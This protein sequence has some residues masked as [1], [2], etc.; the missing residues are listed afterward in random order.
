[1][2]QPTEHV[3]EF[4][5]FRL[6]ALRRVLVR[7]GRTVPL[8]GKVFDT[9]LVLVERRGRVL[10][11][12]E[13]MAALWPDTT[14]EENNLTQHVSML[15]KALGE[16]AGAHRYVVTVPGRG[17]TFVEPVR[18]VAADELEP[19]FEERPRERFL[20]E[21][22]AGLS[23]RDASS[24]A[25]AFESQEP[26]VN[27]KAAGLG[28]AAAF[29]VNETAHT[30]GGNGAAPAAGTNDGA[31]RA[32]RLSR[33]R[34]V[35]ALCVLAAVSVLGYNLWAGRAARD[36]SAAHAPQSSVEVR[37]TRRHTSEVLEARDAYLRGRYFWN[38]RSP[39]GVEKSVEHFRR[40]IDLDPTYGAAYAGLADAYS[41]LGNYRYGSLPADECLRRARAAALKAVEVDDELAEG[42]ASLALVKAYFERDPDGADAEF[43]RAIE[44]DPSYATA[45][46]WYS[47]FLATLGRG[48][49]A[50]SEA[51]RAGELDPLSPIISTTVGE[52][53]YF[54]R[55]Y[56]RAEEQLR[57]TLELDPDFIPARFVLGVVYVKQG[58]R[59]A[60]V[61]ELK[62]ARELARGGDPRV[63]AALGQAY[64]LSGRKAE[65]RRLLGELTAEGEDVSPSDLALVFASLG[66]TEQARAWLSKARDKA[67]TNPELAN[68]L[69]ADPRLDA[70]RAD[71]KFR[72]IF[73]L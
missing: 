32:P 26:A 73:I 61:A 14:V 27:G 70:L 6:H 20:A 18:E 64:A 21:L 52:R 5:P 3:Y 31:G 35:F 28:G 37:R 47:D 1:M 25:V 48:D 66:E 71:P 40:A 46:H 33:R 29:A 41:V 60:A 58:R 57:R 30:V 63:T 8:T 12:D 42:H 45:H 43:R 68:M 56:N 19:F 15:R 69:K 62:R 51:E 39:E 4:G 24:A 65:A 49:E 50:L 38:K 44:L 53:L 13:L 55:D 67:R 34:E 59:A 11:K 10:A 7:E 23:G 22:K 2:E 72:D 54:A 36:D 9:L 17:Y 16:R